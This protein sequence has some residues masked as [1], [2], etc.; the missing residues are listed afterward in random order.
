MHTYPENLEIPAEIHHAAIMVSNFFNKNGIK[1]WMLWD[2]A[3]RKLVDDLSLELNGG[4]KH[5]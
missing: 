4:K 2:I 5:E 1:G 3:D